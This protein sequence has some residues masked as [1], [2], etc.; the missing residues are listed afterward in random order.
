MFEAVWESVRD[1][2]FGMRAKTPAEL[3]TENR[4]TIGRAGR[5][6]DRET[7]L[8][9][10]D[11]KRLMTE[12]RVAAKAGDMTLVKNMAK[13][14]VRKRACISRFH[15]AKTQLDGVATRLAAAKSA[16]A[17]SQT[18]ASA[19][20][21]MMAMSK[22]MNVPAF[23]RIMMEFSKQNANMDNTTEMM[24]DTIDDVF[25]DDADATDDVVGQVLDELGCSIGTDLAA[26][27]LPARHA[28]A[29]PV[30]AS[31][32]RVPVSTPASASEEDDIFQRLERL[33]STR[34]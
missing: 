7:S 4:R 14:L 34:E 6:I 10:R 17:M 23:Q 20:R 19:T 1:Y 26:A 3:L 29:R 27:P 5:E 2:A 13:D 28:A 12:I 22:H 9:R 11:E 15:S 30:A 32:S 24:G 18:M 8:V 21:T 31:E 33:K 25:E 16:A